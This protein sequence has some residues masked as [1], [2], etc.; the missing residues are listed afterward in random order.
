MGYKLKPTHTI[1]QLFFWLHLFSLDIAAGACFMSF[2]FS[3]LLPLPVPWFVY[4]LL[5]NSTLMVYWADHLLDARNAKIAAVS[6]R[7]QFF[8]KHATIFIILMLMLGMANA[9]IALFYVNQVGLFF[10]A[11]ACFAAFFYVGF[12]NRF[13]RILLFEKEVL[14]G[15]IYGFS[16]GLVP[17]VSLGVYSFFIWPEILLI[18]FLIALSTLQNTFS[19]AKI[20]C[21]KDLASAARNL[22]TRYSGSMLTELQ[23]MFF[24]LQL[25]LSIVLFLIS[26]VNGSLQ[27]GI[28]LTANS[29]L[30]FFLPAYA[31][32]SQDESYRYLGEWLFILC[33]VLWFIL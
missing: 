8:K 24:I 16:I 23:I 33:G 15:L 32:V 20:E 4:V 7:H 5:A 9:L 17:I 6:M 14:I 30:Q 10:G 2:A 18:S 25:M 26:P 1:Y 28:I 12:H 27:V 13:P 3:Q 19:I 29:V 11:I 31:K 21:T 22:A